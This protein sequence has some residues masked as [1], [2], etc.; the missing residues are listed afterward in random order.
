MPRRAP[1]LKR[2]CPGEP[3]GQGRVFVPSIDAAARWTFRFSREDLLLA[4]R[5][6]GRES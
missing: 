5:E 3:R 1:S 4:Q 2:A 6:V